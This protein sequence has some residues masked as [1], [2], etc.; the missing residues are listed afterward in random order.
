M[1][2]GDS[3][4]HYI[5]NNPKNL[6][7][8]VMYDKRLFLLMGQVC[9]SV[10]SEVDRADK[11]GVGEVCGLNCDNR[12]GSCICKE[13]ASDMVHTGMAQLRDGELPTSPTVYGLALVY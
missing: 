10:G 12:E 4:T 3:V 5:K 9:W 2:E 11:G 7:P 13:P 6:P 8:W 1:L